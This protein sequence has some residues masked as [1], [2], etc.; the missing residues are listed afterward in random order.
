MRRAADDMSDLRQRLDTICEQLPGAEKSDPWGGGHDAWTFRS[1]WNQAT[2]IRNEFLHRLQLA[3]GQPS[4]AG[5][6]VSLFLNGEYWGVYELQELPHEY[7]N[8]DH[9]GGEPEDWD[10]IKHGEEVESGD[11]AAWNDLIN[12]ARAGIG[13][14]AAYEAI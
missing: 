10:V 14:G 6:Y 1:N 11:L 7:Y 3:M 9:H 4:P 2:L 5:R 8:A 12:Q 13:S